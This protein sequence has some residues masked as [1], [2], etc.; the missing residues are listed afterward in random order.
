MNAS[1]DDISDAV[2]SDGGLCDICSKDDLPALR[3]SRCKSFHLLLWWEGCEDGT[4]EKF[5]FLGREHFG[6]LLFSG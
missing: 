2:D 4:N 6:T 5:I 1:I 3:R